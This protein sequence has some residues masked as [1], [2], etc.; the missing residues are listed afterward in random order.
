MDWKQNKPKL[1]KDGNLASAWDSHYSDSKKI[2]GSQY[3]RARK[4]F[5]SI[6]YTLEIKKDYD[7][8]CLC[9]WDK[10]SIDLAH[11]VSNSKGG[12]WEVDN[13]VPLCPN[14]HRRYDRGLLSDDE[15]RTICSFPE[16]IRDKIAS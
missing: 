3:N 16:S 10:T 11:I 2:K 6:L 1:D 8:C 7:V 4:A 12:E 14:C 9:G 5:L 15:I 13:I